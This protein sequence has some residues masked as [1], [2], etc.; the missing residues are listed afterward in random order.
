[1]IC[2]VGLRSVVKVKAVTFDDFYTLRYPTEEKED[3]IFP[4]LEA[5]KR[6]GLDVDDK[7]FL[8]QYFLEDTLYR[9]RL[10]ETLRESLLDDLVMNALTAC[11]HEGK[12]DEA[13][14]KK[15]V[16]YGLMTR[17]VKWFPSAR[18][19]LAT[20]KRKGYRMALISNTHWRISQS[21]RKEFETFF[22]IITLSY[23]HGYVK[24]HPSIFTVTLEKL[25]VDAND[26]LHVGDDPIADVEGAKN[27]GMKTAF[28]K[29][30]EK[31]TNADIETTR[32]SQLTEFL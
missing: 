12:T 1:M 24:P 22:E 15:A 7:E 10:K 3:I 31:Q 26:C 19:T 23:E 16:D 14:V 9:K 29:R 30:R 27:I 2:V 5:L 21:L 28:I 25:G 17:R 11:G 32:L 6:E 8:K 20:L 18:G 4:V 13:I